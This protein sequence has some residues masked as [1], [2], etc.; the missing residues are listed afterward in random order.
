[1]TRRRVGHLIPFAGAL[2]AVALTYLVGA[3]GDRRRS[4]AALILAGVAIASLL[5][6][7]QTFVQQQQSDTIRLVY[8]WILGR[9]T[10]AGWSEVA[11]LFPYVAVTT[12]VLV[13]HRRMLDVLSVGEAEAATLWLPV[14]RT[15]LIVVVAASLGTAA[16][17]AVSGLI[18]FVGIIV[19][20]TIRLLGGASYR[21]ILPLSMLLGGAF[22]VLADIAA[23]QAVSPAELPI[24]VVTA[25]FGAPFF[26]MLLRTRRG[27]PAT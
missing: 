26:V 16:A 2:V 27:V 21:V 13:A 1:M 10:T 6:A 17:V 23:R 11:L 14:E 15:R 18:G 7:V 9:L 22:L 12:V 19:P 8:S 4:S 25:F 3:T 20:H 5:T 24:G